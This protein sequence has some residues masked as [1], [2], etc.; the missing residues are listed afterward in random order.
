MT[1]VASQAPVTTRPTLVGRDDELV[2]L[3]KRLAE[4]AQGAGSIV[5]LAA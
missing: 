4:A 2:L 5:I 3:R 1:Q